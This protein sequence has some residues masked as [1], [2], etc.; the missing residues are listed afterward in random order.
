M[1][2]AGG[3]PPRPGEVALGFDPAT[4]ADATLAFI[5]R[6]ASPHGPGDC[7]KNLTE[8]RAR[9]GGA[10]LWLDPAWRA[11]LAG[12]VAGRAAIVLY[13]MAGA[14]R[15]LI[16]QAPRHRAQPAGV[17]ALRSPARPN[18]LALAVVRVL[19]VDAAAGRVEIDAIDCW[20]ATPLVDL[21]PWFAGID[22][23][24]EGGADR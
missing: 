11:G 18:P 10:V 20:N 24:P 1:A 7:P 4:R 13:W 14:R 19:A 8:A 5:G 16:V 21:K 15:D 6:I 23:P 3:K 12:V 17:F 9:G 22:L 2:E